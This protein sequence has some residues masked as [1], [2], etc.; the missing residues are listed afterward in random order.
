MIAFWLWQ[1]WRS[2]IMLRCKLGG[3]QYTR[4]GPGIGFYEDGGSERGVFAWCDR[5]HTS[6][7]VCAIP[8]DYRGPVVA[9][10]GTIHG[11]ED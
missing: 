6:L 3:H 4:L 7:W 8:D 2:L 5:C 1:F 11:I 10:F 9:Y